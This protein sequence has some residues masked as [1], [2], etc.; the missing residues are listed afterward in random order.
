MPS[1]EEN[2]RK[3]KAAEAHNSKAN[4]TTALLLMACFIL[5]QADK[6][7]MGLL[8]VPVQN[9]FS[10]NDTQ[11][12]FLQGGAFAIAFALGGLPIAWLL[13]KGHRIR[14]AATCVTVWSLATMLCGIAPSFALLLLFRA[15]TAFAEAGLPPAAFSIFSQSTH[16]ALAARLTGTFMLAPFIGGGGILLL[17][18]VLL[19]IAGEGTLDLIVDIEGWRLVFL[20][21]GTPG[22]LL[23]L[24]LALL[25]Y[26]PPRPSNP[27]MLDHAPQCKENTTS[28]GDVARAIFV[29]RPFLRYY[30][31]GLTCFYLFAAA[32]IG[33]YPALLSRELDLSPATAGGYAGTTY[34]AAGVIG[35]VAM[36]AG[37]AWSG[38]LTNHDLVRVHVFALA[39]LA[40]VS[41][42]LPLVTSLSLSLGLYGLYALLSAAVM[43]SMA[44]PIQT[45]LP[46]DMQA[47]GI[48][49]FSLLMSALAGS[50]GPFMVGFLSD[51][52][53]MRLS[54]SIA[55]VA[56]TSACCALGFL[57]AAYRN[58]KAS[59]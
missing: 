24:A 13:D 40:P 36:T 37:S 7:V 44:V 1:S 10:L 50:I 59:T 21:V 26:E 55:I 11:L 30:Y 35:T 33:W 15:A 49:I 19:G 34:L 32:L 31:L 14:I 58:A 39:L 23:A 5:A 53:S 4:W 28:Y 43:A 42:A 29:H 48:A 25:G 9:A 46:N 38:R 2:A 20:L 12:G 45:S 52:L 56:G 51:S 57:T 8:A 3:P 22:L 47:R 54:Q 18:G 27:S 16:T 17:G 41:I 6:Q